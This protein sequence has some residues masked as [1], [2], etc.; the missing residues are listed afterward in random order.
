MIGQKICLNAFSIVFSI[1]MK[2][3]KPDDAIENIIIDQNG[4][5]DLN[6]TPQNVRGILINLVKIV[7]LSSM[8]WA[9]TL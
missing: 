9:I 7:W 8:V 5:G 2:I 6:F 3:V 1:S 4:L